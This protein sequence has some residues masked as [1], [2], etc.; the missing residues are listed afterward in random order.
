MDVLK[1]DLNITYIFTHVA[2]VL[3]GCC[4]FDERFECSMQHE[5]DVVA[6]FFLIIN[7]WLIIFFNIFL[8]LQMVIVYAAD[9][10]FLCCKY[11]SLMLQ[12]IN[13]ASH[14]KFSIGR[15]GASSAQ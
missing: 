10:Y 6:D 5:I 14:G 4:I 2:T 15:P 3:S 9:V 13:G 11:Y 12:W 7:G 8:I 1:L